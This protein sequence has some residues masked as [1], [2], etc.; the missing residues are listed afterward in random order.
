MRILGIH[1]A[2]GQ[3]R[4]ALLEGTK[5]EPHLVDKGRLVTTDPNLVPELMDWYDSQFRQLLD[6]LSPNKIAYRLTLSPKKEQLFTSEFPLGILNLL[7]HQRNLPIIAY[8]PQAFVPSKLGLK[9][10]ADL[11]QVCDQTFGQQ[12]PHWDK[13]QKYSILV[14]W[15]EL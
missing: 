5:L 10:E 1:L 11:Y 14:A 12:P 2:K 4:Y 13:N 9:K 7:A 6:R 15:F 3:L 8:T